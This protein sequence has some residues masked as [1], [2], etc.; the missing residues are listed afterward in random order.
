MPTSSGRPA[1]VTTTPV[2]TAES[3]MTVP[4]E[5][6][7]PPVMMTKVTPMARMPVTDVASRMP[8]EVADCVM[9]CGDAKVKKTMST[10]QGRQGQHALDGVRLEDRP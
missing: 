8:I 5:R 6:S 7:M 9:K 10:T 3:V 1:L 4:M 2:M